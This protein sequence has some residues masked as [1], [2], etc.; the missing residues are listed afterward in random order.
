MEKVTHLSADA[1]ERL[2]TDKNP[3]SLSM[4]LQFLGKIERRVGE[5]TFDKAMISNGFFKYDAF[6][7]PSI[8]TSFFN[9]VKVNDVLEAVVSR[10]PETTQ[11]LVGDFKVVY[12]DL[13]QVVGM[14]V[15]YREGARNGQ[16]NNLI[17]EV[18]KKGSGINIAQSTAPNYAHEGRR[19]F[20][21]SEDEV[22]DGRYVQFVNISPLDKDFTVKGRL[23]RKE[24]LRQY[25][26][27]QGAPSSLFS[28][29]L[30]DGEVE[31]QGTFYGQQAD[32]FFPMMQEGEMYSIS[33]CE[34]RLGD[35][36]NNTNFKYTL[37]FAR[38][39]EVKKLKDKHVVPKHHFHFTPLNQLEAKKE[40]EKIDIIAIVSDPG[41]AKE[42]VTKAGAKMVKREATLYD[43]SGVAA[44]L[45][46]WRE[47]ATN[48]SFKRD[49][50]IVVKN[51]QI[52]EFQGRHL[53]CGF[54]SQIVTNIPDHPRLKDLIA[55]RRS[56]R[57]APAL[58]M[59]A[60]TF[61]RFNPR[62]AIHLLHKL[63]EESLLADP[64]KK[65]YYNVFGHLTEIPSGLH[66]DGCWEEKCKKKVERDE[67][68]MYFCKACNK[69][70]PSPMPRFFA[71]LV[72]ADF[73]GSI[74]C[75][76]SGEKLCVKLF[77]HNIQDLVQMRNRSQQEFDE[78]VKPGL[79][80]QFLFR[81]NGRY[82]ENY[83][84]HEVR[85]SLMEAE[86]TDDHAILLLEQY[87]EDA[88]DGP[89]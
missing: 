55:F 20:V 27:K 85:F 29:I 26:N 14:P 1:F 33:H 88:K 64:N 32:Q 46:L 82:E 45:V 24:G 17:T 48:D 16:G 87:A 41:E 70:T 31:V 22:M 35:R 49:D 51:A 42:L 62:T 81:L 8:A 65:L 34:T 40:K 39:S 3:R 6:V 2:F 68:G 63:A 83:G 66:Y 67:S 52:E 79:F 12:T 80:G 73:S 25:T 9:Q 28:F 84:K 77:G 18:T 54:N 61:T 57:T 76:A 47:M 59:P 11:V 10:R 44:K 58:P 36:F 21:E 43:D 30:Y 74:R 72:I 5:K 19:V 60:T 53:S 4:T 50:I 71:N 38:N 75:L 23:M 37:G 86:R 69:S 56:N 78:A 13:K 7:H 15:E 89:L